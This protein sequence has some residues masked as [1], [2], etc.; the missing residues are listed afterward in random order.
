[1]FNYKDTFDSNYIQEHE[2]NKLNQFIRGYYMDDKHLKLCDGLIDNHDQE[3][4]KK[5]FYGN[6]ASEL[7][8]EELSQKLDEQLF[9]CLN[10]YAIRFPASVIS[11]PGIIEKCIVQSSFEGKQWNSIESVTV[12]NLIRK[13]HFGFILFLNDVEE[14]GNL[15]FY[16]QKLVI[17]PRKGMIIVYPDNWQHIYSIEPS[18]RELFWLSGHISN[19]TSEERIDYNPKLKINPPTESVNYNFG[20]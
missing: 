3:F 10:N 11:I 15:L 17:K 2:I 16:H 9:H 19:V 5:P 14:G 13:R 8:N 1:M 20:I 6:M 4:H 7:D 12:D 18:K